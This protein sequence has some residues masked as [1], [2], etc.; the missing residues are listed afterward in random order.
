[1]FHTP[2]LWT[3]PIVLLLEKGGTRG[4][5]AT[6]PGSVWVG[7]SH[8]VATDQG[9]GVVVKVYD[10][11]GKGWNPWADPGVPFPMGTA[12]RSPPTPARGL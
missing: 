2:Q 8:R 3:H 5:I 12:G 1:M 11:A 10:V 6:Q 7:A 9:L 4:L